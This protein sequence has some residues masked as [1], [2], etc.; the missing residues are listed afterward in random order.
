MYFVRRSFCTYYKNTLKTRSPVGSAR[1][2][3]EVVYG[4]ERDTRRASRCLRDAV[5]NSYGELIAV[6]P[7]G[8]SSLRPDER[9]GE[10]GPPLAPAPRAQRMSPRGT[11]LL[12]L[13]TLNCC[14]LGLL[15]VTFFRFEG[16]IATEPFF[17]AAANSTK[18]NTIRK[19]QTPEGARSRGARWRE[20]VLF[21]PFCA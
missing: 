18:Q 1:A 14:T 20:L 6:M 7:L 16:E 8:E 10:R 9:A 2:T 13:S 19:D 17:N 3:P 21:T 11:H 5:T 12:A 4:A 15:P